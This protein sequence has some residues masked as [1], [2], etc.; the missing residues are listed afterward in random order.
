VSTVMLG[1][2][3][4]AGTIGVGAVGM[5]AVMA[6]IVVTAVPV[7]TREELK[8]TETLEPC[9]DGSGCGPLSTRGAPE[10]TGAT[11][12]VSTAMLGVW[13]LVGRV[14]VAVVM[15]AVGVTVVPGLAREEM[16]GT[17]TLEPC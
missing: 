2:W 4:L 10:G 11:S 13:V 7:S 9:S 17:E 8:G 3:V 12:M 14:G 15:A 5:A 16:K 1:V 6:A